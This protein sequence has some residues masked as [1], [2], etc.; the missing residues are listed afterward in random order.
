[1]NEN[2]AFL[3]HILDEIEFLTDQCRGLQFQE[4]VD[5]EESDKDID[6]KGVWGL[7]Y[8]EHSIHC[9]QAQWCSYPDMVMVRGW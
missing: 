8:G 9:L 1:M 6:R 4:L 7:I 5:D 3:Q 2:E